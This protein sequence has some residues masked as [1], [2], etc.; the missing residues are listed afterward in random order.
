MVLVGLQ[1]A[2][3]CSG[4]YSQYSCELLARAPA[5]CT[6]PARCACLVHRRPGSPGAHDH[7]V[8]AKELC[9]C[10]CTCEWAC[11]TV[12]MHVWACASVHVCVHVC[13]CVCVC[14]CIVYII[15]WCWIVN[16]YLKMCIHFLCIE[17]WLSFGRRNVIMLSQH[18]NQTPLCVV[19]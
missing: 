4:R 11:V 16:V 19:D 9:F 15:V 18:C 7:S 5:D 8:V 14:S 3:T 17:A 6:A 2:H 13:V 1:G 12:S 10:V